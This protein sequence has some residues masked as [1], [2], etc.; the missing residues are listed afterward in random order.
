[1]RF[2][3]IS[4]KVLTIILLLA[5]T[6][7]ARAQ[8]NFESCGTLVGTA[9]CTPLFEF[10]SGRGSGARRGH[11]PVVQHDLPDRRLPVCEHDRLVRAVPLHADVRGIDCDGG[12][13]VRKSR[14]AWRQ[15]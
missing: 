8:A 3:C 1:M 4:P 7:T 15:F 5:L 9:A 11:D 12:V 10:D 2:C 6:A 14:R 13:S